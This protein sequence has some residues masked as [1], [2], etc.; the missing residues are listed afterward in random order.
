MATRDRLEAFVREALM[1]GRGREEIATTLTSA[2]WSGDEVAQALAAWADVPFAP[3]VPRPVPRFTARDALVYGIVLTALVAGAVHL[4][5]LLHAIIDLVSP[6]RAFSNSGAEYRVRWAS[7]VLLVMGPLYL[8]LDR[9]EAGRQ[10][11]GPMRLSL[12]RAMMTNV[13]LYL[14]AC[15][16]L[17]DLVSVIYALL[18]GGLSWVFALKA[19]AVALV[20]AAIFGRYLP[21]R[22][23][24]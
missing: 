8:W 12:A 16:L 11:D 22:G 4:V 3:P 15:V 5:V 21:E 19:A 9:R 18:D 2:G 24:R 7:S 23:A 14:S 20:A 1:A 10:R 13:A 17:G 6:G